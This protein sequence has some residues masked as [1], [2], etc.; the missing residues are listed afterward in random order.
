MCSIVCICCITPRPKR[1]MRKMLL[2]DTCLDFHIS[3]SCIDSAISFNYM[4]LAYCIITMTVCK[5]WKRYK[6]G[7]GLKSATGNHCLAWTRRHY[8]HIDMFVVRSANGSDVRAVNL[9]HFDN[10]STSCAYDFPRNSLQTL[11]PAAFAS[12]LVDTVFVNLFRTAT[13]HERVRL[14]RG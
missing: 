6:I 4:P 14:A 12:A 7:A 8:M 5:T 13:R 10:M 11:E 2:S 1:T 9:A 3:S